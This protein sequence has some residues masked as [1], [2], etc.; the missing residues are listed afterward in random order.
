MNGHPAE[1]LP[2]VPS[3]SKLYLTAAGTAAKSRLLG[4]T[5]P[6]LLPAAGHVV[7]GVRADV[8]KL[9][10]YQHLLSESARDV[11]PSGYLHALAFPVAMSVMVRPDFPLPLLG[12][13][14][15]RNQVEHFSPV[16]YTTPLTITAWARGLQGHRAGTQVEIVAE[17]RPD[18]GGEVLWRGRSSYLAKGVFLPGLDH[19]QPSGRPQPSSHP[20]PSGPRESF[21]PPVP[22]GIWT[23]GVDTGRA[24]AAVSGDFNPIHLSVLSAKVLGMRRSLAHGMY[25]AA[26]ILHDVG[27]PKPDAFGWDIVFE[28]PVFLPARVAVTI[29]DTSGDDGAWS[30]S[31]FTGWNQRT[32]RRHFHGTMAAL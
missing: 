22:T 4:G 19:P 3:L 10:E 26:R 23:L 7:H 28:A 1:V 6:S 17:V 29:A 32:G 24:Y 2:E 31:A 8:A 30:G 25:L 18:G 11:L 21:D 20:Q 27:S 16:L 5:G 13:V 9:T 12:M 14:H 15:L